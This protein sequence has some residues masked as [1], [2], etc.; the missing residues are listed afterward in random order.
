VTLALIIGGISLAA[1]VYLLLL[2]GMFWLMRERDDRDAPAEP[3][4]WPAVVA[5][6]PARNE[7]DVIARSV[8]SLLG[9]DFAG[10]FRLVLVDDD[11]QDG[12]GNVAVVAATKIGAQARLD[13]IAGRPL[14]R[15]CAG[16]SL[17]PRPASW[18][19][20]P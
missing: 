13:L 20:C 16:W 14:A 7:A 4:A 6:V 19:W 1:W 10:E 9:Q 3:A 5:V 12:T 17:A 18:R 11:S 8:T 15:P 2:R